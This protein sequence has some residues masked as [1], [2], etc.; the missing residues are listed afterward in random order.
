MLIEAIRKKKKTNSF[1]LK[2]L[3]QC[4]LSN[5]FCLENKQICPHKEQ[6]YWYL[7]SSRSVEEQFLGRMIV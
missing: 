7:E 4:F 1:E 5:V 2:L 6:N 3:I